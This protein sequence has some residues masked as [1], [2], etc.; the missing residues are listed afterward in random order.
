LHKKCPKNVKI[1]I[2]EKPL[3]MPCISKMQKISNLTTESGSKQ[4]SVTGKLYHLGSM[5]E[6]SGSKYKSSGRAMGI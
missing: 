3:T 6:N 5:A 1:Y 2:V 4:K